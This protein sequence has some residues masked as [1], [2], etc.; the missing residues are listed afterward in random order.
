MEETTGPFFIISLL[1]SLSPKRTQKDSGLTFIG[2]AH[3]SEHFASK[4]PLKGKHSSVAS[5]LITV[6]S[7]ALLTYPPL[8]PLLAVSQDNNSW[9][10]KG[11]NFFSSASI[12]NFSDKVEAIAVA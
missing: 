1:I 5:P 11:V 3:I 9:A 12:H 7:K 2:S 10:D 6:Y 4:V 8:Q